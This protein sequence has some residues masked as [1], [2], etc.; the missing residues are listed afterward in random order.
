M[1]T[2]PFFLVIEFV[3]GVFT[4]T[5]F[6]VLLGVILLLSNVF[7]C[8]L[9]SG[10]D[11]LVKVICRFPPFFWLLG[12]IAGSLYLALADWSTFWTQLSPYLLR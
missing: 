7:L 11:N 3:L 6:S 4:A 10:S 2:Y 8:F 12:V 1:I 9:G 5:T